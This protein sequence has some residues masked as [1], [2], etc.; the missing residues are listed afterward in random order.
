[1][2]IP[3]EVIE[4]VR[5]RANLQDIAGEYVT[6][7]R[8]GSG[9]VGLS[10][11]QEEKTPSFHIYDDGARYKCFSSGK[12]GDAIG[13]IIEMKG[14]SFPEAVRYLAGKL[15]IPI[16]ERSKAE[17]EREKIAKLH[18][19]KLRE[20]LSLVTKI[21]QQELSSSNFAKDYLK[22]RGI[23][24][25]SIEKF[26]LGYAPE[27]WQFLQSK[28]TEID[29]K[30]L[31]KMGLVKKKGD[32]AFD[33][34]RNRLMFPITRSDGAPIAFG[35]RALSASEK[36]PKYLNSPENL[37][38]HKRKTLYGI[39]QATESL[40]KTRHAYI[41]EG[42]FDVISMHQAEMAETV[43]TCGTAVGEEHAQVLKRLV[44]K[45]TILFDGDNAGKRAA[46]SCF[47]V[48]LN[49]GVEVSAVLL[50]EGKD[51]DNLSQA[52]SKEKLE[53]S[54]ANNKKLIVDIY[55]DHLKNELATNTGDLSAASTGKLAERFVRVVNKAVNPVEREYLL[56]RGADKLGVSFS[57]LETLLSQ[58]S[59]KKIFREQKVSTQG[60]PP[61]PQ[62]YLAEERI[63]EKIEEAK[64]SQSEVETLREKNVRAFYSQLIVAV[65][66]E[67]QSAVSFLNMP[68]IKEGMKSSGLFSDNVEK[69]IREYATGSFPAVVPSQDENY[70]DVRN[71]L[72]KYNLGDYD[73]VELALSQQK[74]GGSRPRDVIEDTARV[75]SSWALNE[76]VQELRK[77]EAIEQSDDDRLRLAQDKL[78]KKRSLKELGHS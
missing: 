31:F 61:L 74:I 78:L 11:F 42:Y 38:Y 13:F 35:G 48:F 69:F 18:R 76:E 50:P 25:D 22:S 56:K 45:V 6:L 33:L 41:V 28:I 73:Y 10:P 71:L 24:D 17:D 23:T 46:A 2:A 63:V 29:E 51:P 39:H 32:K 43:A 15:G 5:E 12:G 59:D 40:R 58:Q 47:E 21:Y 77:K 55:I 7:K 19:G 64:H 20:A 54:F 72:K 34:F 66:A 70:G 4:Q 67:P 52:Y 1:M 60:P 27:A 49:S 68:S 9:M 36:G 57:S 37:I 30:L 75:T 26:S 53:K 65:L 44:D 62:G 8:S 14:Y 16:P 3:D